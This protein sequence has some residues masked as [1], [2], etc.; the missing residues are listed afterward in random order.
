MDRESCGDD[1]AEANETVIQRSVPG[2]DCLGVDR[3]RTCESAA[4][5]PLLGPSNAGWVCALLVRLSSYR[6]SGSIKER[7]RRSSTCLIQLNQLFLPQSRAR[8]TQGAS[9]PLNPPSLNL[10][11]RRSPS[12][13]SFP[14]ATPARWWVPTALSTGCRS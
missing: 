7:E 10:A 9:D 11:L 1:V 2:G 4:V 3:F 13:R 12:T 8:P 6:G 14:T 5:G